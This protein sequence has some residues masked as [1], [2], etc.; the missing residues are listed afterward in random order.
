MSEIMAR[1]ASE[2]E[3]ATHDDFKA[4]PVGDICVFVDPV[5]G[6]KVCLCMCLCVCLVSVPESGTVGC[7]GFGSKD[8]KNSLSRLPCVRRVYTFHRL[9]LYGIF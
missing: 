6:T 8:A 1:I 2:F 9:P 7:R 5:D 3:L 4:V